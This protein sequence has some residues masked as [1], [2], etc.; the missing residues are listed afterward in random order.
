MYLLTVVLLI[1]LSECKLMF[2]ASKALRETW[3]NKFWRLLMVQRLRHEGSQLGVTAWCHSWRSW[4]SGGYLHLWPGAG[5]V[6]KRVAAQA[7]HHVAEALRLD[8]GQLLHLVHR[9]EVH[10]LLVQ[11]LLLPGLRQSLQLP[12]LERISTAP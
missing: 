2:S 4:G 7:G 10:L 1:V 9:L 12:L 5:D 8:L 3:R 6:T 11:Q